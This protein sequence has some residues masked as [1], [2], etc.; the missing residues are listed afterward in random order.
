MTA[1]NYFLGRK[2]YPLSRKNY[3]LGEKFFLTEIITA[4]R[5]QA[6]NYDNYYKQDERGQTMSDIHIITVI[7]NLRPRIERTRKV[8]LDDL[9]DE[10]AKQSG[11]DR[12]DARDFAYKF[13]QSMV[14]HLKFGD[15]VQLGDIGG[16]AVSCDKDK[17]LKV[18]YRAAKAI[19]A[20]LGQDFRGS[21][22]NGVNANLDDEGFAALW[23]EE[24]A[25]DRVIMRDG[26]TRP[27]TP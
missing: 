24:H 14:S 20:E 18:N 6:K 27:A 22:V 26:S 8:T 11:F 3:P 13:A 25:E 17:N 19:T 7:N 4:L 5:N 12:G 10:I 21:F 2:N 15:Y 1:R 16:F 23:L 9:A